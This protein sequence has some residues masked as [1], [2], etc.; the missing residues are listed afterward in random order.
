[1]HFFRYTRSNKLSKNRQHRYLL[2]VHTHSNEL[3]LWKIL[4]KKFYKNRTGIQIFLDGVSNKVTEKVEGT[5]KLGI[6]WPTSR[7]HG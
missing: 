2:L 5:P 7:Q 4:R 3:H 1:M 6:D